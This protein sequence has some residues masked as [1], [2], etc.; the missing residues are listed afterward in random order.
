MHCVVVPALLSIEVAHSSSKFAFDDN[1]GFVEQSSAVRTERAR[2]VRDKVSQTQIKLSRRIVNSCV[3][4]VNVRVVIPSA[5]ID[6]KV[7]RSE[8]RS[9]EVPSDDARVAETR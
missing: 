4:L 5:E 9:Y 8:I 2:E 3:R 7:T 6:L 1:Q